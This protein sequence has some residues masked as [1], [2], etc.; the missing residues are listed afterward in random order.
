[1]W[2]LKIGQKISI[3]AQGSLPLSVGCVT[4]SA[5]GRTLASN[6]KGIIK[7]CDLET[8][9]QKLT[10]K[11]HIAT[12][13]FLAISRDGQTLASSSYDKTIK[14]WDL[15]KVQE[16]GLIAESNCNG[17]SLAISPD[18]QTLAYV[19]IDV[20]KVWDCKTRHKI[21]AIKRG[22]FWSVAFSPDEQS[23]A[24]SAEDGLIQTW[25]LTTGQEIQT[26]VGHSLCVK[27]IAI[28]AN[29]QTLVRGR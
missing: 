22:E 19:S 8:L 25:D 23:L 17:R 29:R 10:F 14:I 24:S 18:G 28:S 3:L 27:S 12:I 20:L 4:L 15:R 6:V 11:A 1:M 7:V 16:I 2:D 21:H 5:E 9:K 13:T 26:L